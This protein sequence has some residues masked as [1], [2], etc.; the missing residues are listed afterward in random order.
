MTLTAL[1]SVSSTASRTL[2]I[3]TRRAKAEVPSMGSITQRRPVVPGVSSSSSPVTPSS[4][5]RAAISDRISSST[6]MSA[7]VMSVPS[8]FVLTGT[9]SRNR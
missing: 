1:P 8:V 9:P 5:K 6:S 3:G 4:G 7:G 2:N